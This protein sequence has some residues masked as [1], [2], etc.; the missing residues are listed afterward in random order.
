L[1]ATYTYDPING[2]TAAA[3]H[4]AVVE[5]DPATHFVKIHKYV[6]PKTAAE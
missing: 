4:I 1:S 2:T 6:V 3:T 5:V